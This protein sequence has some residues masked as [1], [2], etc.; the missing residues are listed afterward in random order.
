MI[1]AVEFHGLA[2]WIGAGSIGEPYQVGILPISWVWRAKL[3]LNGITCWHPRTGVMDDKSTRFQELAAIA[4]SATV[5]M[6]VGSSAIL[7]TEAPEEYIGKWAAVGDQVPC[8]PGTLD[9]FQRFVFAN[10][11]LLLRRLGQEFPELDWVNDA[12]GSAVA[13]IDT[14][15]GAGG[16]EQQIWDFYRA[17]LDPEAA[18]PSGPS[19]LYD[20]ASGPFRANIERC[21]VIAATPD[22]AADP[23]MRAELAYRCVVFTEAADAM[24]RSE[25]P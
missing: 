12:V 6:P 21:R 9:D 8:C 15:S 16:L 23:V 7:R 18:T 2:P 1:G 11:S 20:D 13:V 25:T 14:L 5:V 10:E 24:R 3:I 22:D 4:T 17:V 19:P